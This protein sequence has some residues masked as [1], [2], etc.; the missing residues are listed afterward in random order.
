MPVVPGGHNGLP[1]VVGMT[2]T[3]FTAAVG[4]PHGTDVDEYLG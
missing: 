3:T 2:V 4:D 1:G